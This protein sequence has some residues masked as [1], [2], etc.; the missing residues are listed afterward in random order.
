MECMEERG[1][2]VMPIFYDVYPWE[3]TTHKWKYG[4]A[5]AKS[6]LKNNIKVESWKKALVDATSILG[7]VTKY[8]ANGR[9][10]GC[11]KQVVDTISKRLFP[12][13][14]FETTSMTTLT[15]FHEDVEHLKIPLRDILLATKT[16]AKENIIAGGGF[17]KVY[18]GQSQQHGIIA[19][20]QL[21]RR[22]GQGD[23]EFMMEIALLST[24]KHENIV[25]LVGYCDQDGEKIL[26]YKYEM[27]GSLD[28]LIH[29]R[30]LTWIQRLQI[31]IDAASG[32]SYLHNDVGPQHRILHR[33]I[34]S[35]NILLDE[36]LKAKISD[37]G[38]SKIVL[39]NVPCTVVISIPC[40]TPGY[41]DPQY[42]RR[43]VLTQKSDVYSFGV[44]LFE[45]LFGRLASLEE[46]PD[47]S[48]FSVQSAQRHFRENTLDEIIDSDL[49]K[50][51]NL[52]SL[53]TFSKIASDCLKEQGEERPTMSKVVEELKKA[54]D[55][56]LAVGA[57]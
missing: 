36:N 14:N 51:M 20:K 2:I 49:W 8:I 41:V 53:S 22:N 55:H 40:G 47:E 1:Q 4:E 46:H 23:R 43:N 21:D 3:V 52:A 17:G 56:Q 48:H 50:Q 30:S 57:A 31:C 16:F 11:V 24:Y 10:A 29:S 13:K 38:L 35:A 28:K 7:W 15:S 6:E 54:L 39:A 9:E 34:K 45:V 33:D 37:F 32:L 5:F 12:T 27:N 18:Q 44:V 26:V 25:Y 42:L 19:V